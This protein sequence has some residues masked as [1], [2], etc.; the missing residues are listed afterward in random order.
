MGTF[1]SLGGLARSVGPS[2]IGGLFWLLGPFVSFTLGA[3]AT[4]G[5]SI[6]LNRLP[7]INTVQSTSHSAAGGTTKAH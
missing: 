6:L 7:N 4:I 3:L 2:I 1:R 5:V